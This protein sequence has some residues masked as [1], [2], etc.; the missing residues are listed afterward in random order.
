M[1][2]N[3][4][5]EWDWGLETG[6]G[7]VTVGVSTRQEPVYVD[8]PATPEAAVDTFEA[9]MGEAERR[10]HKASYYRLLLD[11]NMF[12]APDD[13]VAREVEQEMRVYVKHRLCILL[14]IP[15]SNDVSTGGSGPFTDHEVSILKGFAA[16]VM[17]NPKLNKVV[18][19]GRQEIGPV[20]P[21]LPPAPPK[22][23]LRQRQLPTRPAAVVPP[24]PRQAPQLAKPQAPVAEKQAVTARPKAGRPPAD[25][26]V[27]KEGSKT[28]KVEWCK[29]GSPDEIPQG[30]R[31][32]KMGNGDLFMIRLHDVSMQVEDQGRV[33]MPSNP[34]AFEQIS[35]MKA[36]E[37]L[38]HSS[39]Q[40][41]KI[42]GQ[43]LSE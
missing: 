8:E 21:V 39:P 35:M 5:S 4:E 23:Q 12:S 10:L 11:D 20:K 42:A 27:F 30:M 14:N 1:S 26:S 13:P 7:D 16:Q 41:A 19:S 40:A 17:K 34:R 29:V 9:E 22:P 2:E 31:G 18:S 3:P 33:P 43:I 6:A 36:A 15:T 37:S 25:G 28:Y 38:N 24:P 32:V